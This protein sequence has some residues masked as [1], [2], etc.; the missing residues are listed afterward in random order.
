MVGNKTCNSTNTLYTRIGMHVYKIF[1]T[2]LSSSVNID[3]LSNIVEKETGFPCI[4]TILCGVHLFGRLGLLE[5][6][7]LSKEL[8]YIEVNKMHLF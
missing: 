6:R 3:S 4:P 1:I 7:H 2:L 5:H 8:C